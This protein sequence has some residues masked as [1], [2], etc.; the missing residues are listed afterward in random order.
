MYECIC[1]DLQQGQGFHADPLDRVFLEVPGVQLVLFYL[2]DP[3][4]L[5]HPVCGYESIVKA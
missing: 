5:P 4:H 2:L 3:Q 1:T